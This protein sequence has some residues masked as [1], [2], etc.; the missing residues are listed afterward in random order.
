MNI[1]CMFK[2]ESKVD[3][4]AADVSAKRAFIQALDRKT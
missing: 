4:N 1:A 2:D 3:A